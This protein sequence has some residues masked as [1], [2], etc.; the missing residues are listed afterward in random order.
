MAVVAQG[1]LQDGTFWGFAAASPLVFNCSLFFSL[2]KNVRRELSDSDDDDTTT[3]PPNREEH[4]LGTALPVALSIPFANI[5]VFFILLTLRRGYVLSLV[6]PSIC[7]ASVV[8]LCSKLTAIYTLQN[9]PEVVST[10]L[11][12]APV[13]TTAVR[14]LKAA[15]SLDFGLMLL[16]AYPAFLRLKERMYRAARRDIKRDLSDQDMAPS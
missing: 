2:R 3:R 10:S 11:N 7:T 4:E 16:T 5:F 14:A 13:S 15:A 12:L 1:L 6:V 8:G 9:V